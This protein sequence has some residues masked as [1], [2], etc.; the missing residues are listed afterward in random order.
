MTLKEAEEYISKQILLQY[1]FCEA[2][3]I[4]KMALVH[5]TGLGNTEY[6]LSY[7]DAIDDAI[8]PEMQ[9]ITNRLQWGEPIQYVTGKAHFYGFDFDVN[10]SVLIPRRETEELVQWIVSK[11]PRREPLRIVDICTGSGCIAITLKKLLPLTKVSAL[12]VS[13]AALQ[14]A[15]Q[16]ATALHAE[17]DFFKSDVL[18]L[19]KLPFDD[20][21]IMVSNPPYVTET[22]KSLMHINV[23]NHEPHLALF[24][25]DNDPLIFYRKIAHLALQHLVEGGQLYFEINEKYG[26]EIRQMLH[27]MGFSSVELRN[28]MQGKAR[29]I[30][31]IR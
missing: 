24:V 31:A 9:R 22:E 29:M 3:I 1:D 8:L 23:L 19:E 26:E 16:N 20:I 17:I 11:N 4:A 14:T 13:E 10:P 7:F 28:D 18:E 15:M 30:K 21:Q 27:E 6:S 2:S 12:D 25:P 5:I